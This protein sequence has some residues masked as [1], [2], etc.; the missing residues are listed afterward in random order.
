MKEG[1]APDPLGGQN[2]TDF[3]PTLYPRESGLLSVNLQTRRLAMSIGSTNPSKNYRSSG[4]AAQR[5]GRCTR[6]LDRWL[7]QGIFPEPD[8]VINGR[9]LW[10]DETLDKFDEQQKTARAG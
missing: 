3:C 8:L 2:S 10:S 5:Y 1:R 9:R 7:A 4:K 6:T